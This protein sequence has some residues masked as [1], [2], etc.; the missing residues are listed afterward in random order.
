M[1]NAESPIVFVSHTTKRASNNQEDGTTVTSAVNNGTSDIEEATSKAETVAAYSV[2][3]NY[4]QTI[5]SGASW[6]PGHSANK[7]VV[8]AGGKATRDVDKEG[9]CAATVAM[10]CGI[11]GLF[12]FGVSFSELLL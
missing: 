5:P 10:V 6:A 1:T 12:V 2:P 9:N 4:A 11:V 7:A 8:N 3:V